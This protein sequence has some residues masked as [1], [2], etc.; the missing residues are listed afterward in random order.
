[1]DLQTAFSLTRALMDQ[2]GLTDWVLGADQAKRRA[3]RCNVEQKVITISV[4]LARLY[5]EPMVRETA[6]HEIAHA[7]AGAAHNHD[8]VWRALA[9]SIGSSGER[10]IPEDAPSIDGSWHGSCPAGHT[11][12]ALRRPTRV[13]CCGHC[14]RSFSVKHLV[15]WTWV[16]SVVRMHPAYVAELVQLRDIYGGSPGL[17]E[18]LDADQLVGGGEQH[19]AVQARLTPILPPGSVVHLKKLNG[20]VDVQATVLSFEKTRYRLQVGKETYWASPGAL[21]PH[22][23]TVNEEI[24]CPN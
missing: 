21:V 24:P 15:A 22:R 9:L 11:Q 20:Q 10:C 1:M 12:T 4:P 5:D 17:T 6:L 14:T 18:Q 2:H 7:L 3:G 19:A 23:S 8:D 16:G 13:R